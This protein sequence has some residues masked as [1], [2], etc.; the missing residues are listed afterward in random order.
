MRKH[1]AKLSKGIDAIN[2]ALGQFVAYATFLMAIIM[3]AIVVLRYGFNLGWIAMQESVTYLHAAVFLLGSAFTYQQNAHVRVD[4][5]YR[6]FSE[7]KKAWVN[8]IGSLI[9][10][11]PVSLY[12]GIICFEYVIDS[13][14][15]LE[16]SREPGGLPFVYVLKSFLLV[17]ATS[18]V[19]QAL[20]DIA[21]QALSL[22]ELG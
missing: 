15:L 2:T 20:S 6:Q 9:F 19:L 13:W 16:G 7:R 10:M 11:L 1:I 14:A 5:F 4:V 12:I 18:M 8:L 3:F 21:K 17:F 22:R